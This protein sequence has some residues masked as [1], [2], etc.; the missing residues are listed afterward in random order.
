MW[1]DKFAINNDMLSLLEFVKGEY[2]QR[3]KK[4][5]LKFLPKLKQYAYT[6]YTS[7][8]HVPFKL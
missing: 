2:L 6:T 5:T 8:L 4:N 1:I 7:I 3:I